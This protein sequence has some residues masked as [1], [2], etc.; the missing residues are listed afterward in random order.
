MQREKW[1]LNSS[2]Y[3]TKLLTVIGQKPW[4][5]FLQDLQPAEAL[6]YVLSQFAG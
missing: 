5:R 1:L 4:Q 6:A 3:K 2:T